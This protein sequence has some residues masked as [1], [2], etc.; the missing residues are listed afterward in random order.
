VYN[1][2]APTRP[3][4]RL[5]ADF[6]PSPRKPRVSVLLSLQLPRA[7][8]ALP[9]VLAVAVV[10]AA[11]QRP[12]GG[13]GEGA[14]P[15]ESVLA[16]DS[17]ASFRHPFT[18]VAGLRELGGSRVLV[19]DRGET[20]VLVADLATG[21]TVRVGGEGSGPGEYAIPGG[22]FALPRD[23]TLLVDEGA[24]RLAVIGPGGGIVRTFNPP[25]GVRIIGLGGVG[26]GGEL[27]F[28]GT[29]PT[30]AAPRAAGAADSVP[31]LRWRPGGTRVDTLARVGVPP[32]ATVSLGDPAGG[33]VSRI[34]IPQPFA[35]GDAWG[36]SPRGELLI[37]RAG[38]FALERRGRD[39]ALLGTGGAVTRPPV[40]VTDRDREAFAFGP[41]AAETIRWP[42]TKSPFAAGSLRVSPGGEAWVQLAT[43][44]DDPAPLYAV[45]GPDGSLARLVRLPGGRRLVGLG[46]ASVYAVRRDEDDL[47]WLERYAL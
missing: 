8:S 45:L 35:A 4:A 30:A 47:E 14:P 43:P 42:A 5:R 40:A 2:F 28:Q 3:S 1:W 18:A 13:R 37:L 20:R 41:R 6:R 26:P 17:A 9:A 11:C 29:P 16:A 32:S 12:A 21:D 39:G 27:Y 46:R 23:S 22:L 33:M 38:S 34:S 15:A 7:R 36:V 31:I 44:G 24:Q 25:P 19:S 10:L